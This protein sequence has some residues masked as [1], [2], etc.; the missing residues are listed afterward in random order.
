M[1]KIV[2]F[3][4]EAAEKIIKSEID[5]S[6]LSRDPANAIQYILQLCQKQNLPI[7]FVREPLQKVLTEAY[8]SGV[9]F[10]NHAQLAEVM[11]R[12]YAKGMF[13]GANET[14][15]IV[16]ALDSNAGVSVSVQAVAPTPQ[17]PQAPVAVPI[18]APVEQAPLFDTS[19][20]VESI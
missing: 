14:A 1:M 20:D 11:K 4:V 9:F 18:A 17:V 16:L 6:G 2:N 12:L 8:A 7:E 19:H 5:A 10:V 15:P 3:K 13:M